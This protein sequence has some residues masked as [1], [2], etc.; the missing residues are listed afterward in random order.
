MNS[1]TVTVDTRAMEAGLQPSTA[2]FGTRLSNAGRVCCT[3]S[4]LQRKWSGARG[5]KRRPLAPDPHPRYAAGRTK[6]GESL[7][8]PGLKAGGR[9]VP[10]RSAFAY[11]LCP[12]RHGREKRREEGNQC[13]EPRPGVFSHTFIS[14][15]AKGMTLGVCTSVHRVH[16][17]PNPR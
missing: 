8:V 3:D 6:T 2:A 10:I 17:Y 7:I 9:S 14:P 13:A 15:L 12:R 1:A 5:L 11:L 16:I 4:E